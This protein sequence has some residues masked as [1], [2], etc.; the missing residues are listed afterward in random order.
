MKTTILTAAVLVA[1]I[2]M[3]TAA[4]SADTDDTVTTKPTLAEVARDLPY[5]LNPFDGRTKAPKPCEIDAMVAD[6]PYVAN[7]F[8]GRTHAPGVHC[9]NYR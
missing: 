6:M 7:P 1:S 4:A 2:A 9:H 3:P 8:D 5:L